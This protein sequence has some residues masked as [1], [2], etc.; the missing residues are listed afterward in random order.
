[1]RSLAARAG[2]V[3]DATLLRRVQTDD[4]VAFALL[5]DRF[6]RRAFAVAHGIARD[7]TRAE[8]IV[9]DAFLSLWREC[10]RYDPARGRPAAWILGIVR[11]R[12]I[13]AG[14]RHRRHDSR[15]ADG[16]RLE[17][18]QPARDDVEAATI[19]RDQAAG[20]RAAM[21][22]LPAE[23]REVIALAYFGE[24]S[25]SEIAAELALPLGT[26][27]GR[28]RLGLDRLRGGEGLRGRGSA[29]SGAG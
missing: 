14:R 5:Y 22:Q 27:K 9:Q 6:E 2:A 8:D 13:D 28:M 19:E 25:A 4:T 20:V 29:V 17:E 7:R 16:D 26:V 23:Q 1:M 15:R 12:A 21:A 11:H 3:D 24:L 10:A 18:Q